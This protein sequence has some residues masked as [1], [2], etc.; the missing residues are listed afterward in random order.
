MKFSFST[1]E[2]SLYHKYVKFCI[3]TKNYVL[4]IGFDTI[5]DYISEFSIKSADATLA[6]F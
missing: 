3:D 5:R 4:L 2:V 1:G 6:S